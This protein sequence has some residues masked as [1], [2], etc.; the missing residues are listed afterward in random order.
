VKIKVLA[1]L[2]PSYPSTSAPQLQLLSRYIGA[3]GVDSNLF[4]AILR[5]F[6]SSNG[7]EW[8]PDV[9][10]VFD[11]IQNVLERCVK[12]Y[13]ERLSAEK[14]G[15]LLRE[16]EKEA[17]HSNHQ[18]PPPLSQ[19]HRGQDFE[20][21]LAHLPEGIEIFEAEPIV[22][23]KSSFVGRACAISDPSQVCCGTISDAV[24]NA[25]DA[26]KGP[27]DFIA[28]FL[29]QAYCAS[30]SSHYKRLAMPGWQYPASR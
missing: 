25:E 9:V 11:G 26:L 4:G 23:R 13:E 16:D 27:V 20:P 28:F 15:E 7:V 30:S 29:R 22:D 24:W 14:A 8:T 2:P 12:W 21:P 6:I 17:I 3:F 10:C 5:T 1:S 18:Q 19:N